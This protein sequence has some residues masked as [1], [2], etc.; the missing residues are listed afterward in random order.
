MCKEEVLA[1]SLEQVDLD[2]GTITLAPEDAKT[3]EPRPIVLTARA[4]EA[5]AALHAPNQRL[6]LPEPQDEDALG[7]REEASSVR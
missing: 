2:A 1:L 4:K 7:G 3:D 6:R 5:L